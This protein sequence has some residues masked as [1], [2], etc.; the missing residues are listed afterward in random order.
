[1][2]P[3]KKTK[4]K[5]TILIFATLT[6]ATSTFAVPYCQYPKQPPNTGNS[7]MTGFVTDNCRLTKEQIRHKKECDAISDNR[8]REHLPRSCWA[9]YKFNKS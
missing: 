9:L 3:G 2:N 6:L 7:L 8:D 5:T 1:M 4:M